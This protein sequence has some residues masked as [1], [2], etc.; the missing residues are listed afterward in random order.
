MLEVKSVIG[1]PERIRI[2]VNR[3]F[4]AAVISRGYQLGRIGLHMKELHALSPVD[5][6]SC[7]S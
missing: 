6:F 7:T 3:I 1:E 4:K 5:I 2:L